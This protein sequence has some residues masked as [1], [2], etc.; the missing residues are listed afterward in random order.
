MH[1]LERQKPSEQTTAR[2]S[3]IQ[4]KTK[5]TRDALKSSHIVDV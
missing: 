2:K 5:Q 1:I 4:E 3:K